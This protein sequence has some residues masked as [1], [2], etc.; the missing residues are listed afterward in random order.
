MRLSPTG[1]HVWP[2]EGSWTV[3]GQGGP[4]LT[5][6]RRMKNHDVPRLTSQV[7]LCVGNPLHRYHPEGF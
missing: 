6:G 7:A 1:L 4:G 3:G 2:K 5:Q